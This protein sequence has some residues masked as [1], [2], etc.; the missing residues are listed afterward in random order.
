MEE[1]ART[2]TVAPSVTRFIFPNADVER[3]E[4][5][6]RTV[7]NIAGS[8]TTNDNVLIHEK[9]KCLANSLVCQAF[10]FFVDQLYT[11]AIVRICSS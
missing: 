11:D 9:R 6:E 10:S 3:I 1:D 8:W 5:Q 4:G 7:A 2:G